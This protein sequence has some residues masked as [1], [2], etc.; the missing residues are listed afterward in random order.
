MIPHSSD[1]IS[2]AD[3]SATIGYTKGHTRAL[4]VAHVSA[5]DLITQLSNLLR[6][7][8][9]GILR[10]GHDEVF[11]ARAPGRLDVMGGLS[12][13]AGSLACQWPLA[14]STAVALQRRDDRKLVL[15]NY[16]T[17]GVV[18]LSLDDFYGTASLLPTD[19]LQKLFSGE[20]SWAAHIAG[21]YPTLGKHKK[22]TRRAHGANI[23]CYSDLPFR[24]G[25]ASSAAL[26]CA[27][28][29]ALTAAYHLILDP[30]EIALLAQKI[31]NQLVGTLAGVTEPAASVLGR[32]DQLLLLRC[33]P[34]EHQGYVPLPAGLMIAGLQ[35]GR[36]DA[37]ACRVTR[38]SAFMA[39]AIISRLYSDTGIKKDPT[40]GYLANVSADALGK[41]FRPMLPETLTGEQFIKDYGTIADRLTTVDPAGNY[42]PR[43]AAEFHIQENARAGAFVQHLRAL[44]EPLPAAERQAHAIEAGKLM[45]VSHAACS[46]EARLGSEAADLLVELVT[47]RGPQGGL[48]GARLAGGEGGGGVTV[49]A[50]TTAREQL[51]AIV[52]DYQEKT[53]KQVFLLAGSSDGA[54]EAAPQRVPLTDISGTR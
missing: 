41:Y 15:K 19:S 27:T 2:I 47:E 1:I 44:A 12:E 11:L 36:Q 30:M 46:R 21:A 17:Q 10:D 49:L 42:Y 50:E 29:W 4:G 40:H 54:A 18:A 35:F 53:G 6:S 23:A 33:Q 25:A 9:A 14:A 43:A 3:G 31:E 37:A 28:L 48:Y 22:L 20:N 5:P 13:Y 8:A 51:D 24:A 32:K 38:V 26:Q 39:Q 52:R 16:N 34:H 7:D 45:L